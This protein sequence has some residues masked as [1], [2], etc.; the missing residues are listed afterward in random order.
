MACQALDSWHMFPEWTQLAREDKQG[1]QLGQIVA[2][3]VS[4]CGFWWVN[5]CHILR[6][7]DS[8]STHGFVYGTLPQHAEC[9][10]DDS[11]WYVISAFSHPRH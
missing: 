3:V 6:R 9:G 7:F 11:V 1:Q 2:M 4:I 5:P 8:P 10:E